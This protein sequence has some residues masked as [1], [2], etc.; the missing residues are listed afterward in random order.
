MVK[1]MY[2][3]PVSSSNFFLKMNKREMKP[4]KRIEK[5]RWERTR[6]HQGNAV[7]L[8]SICPSDCS[9][10]PV[11]TACAKSLLTVSPIMI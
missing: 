5:V 6:A 3:S 9:W 10:V 4:T 1:K 7:R 8:Y 2:E 11:M